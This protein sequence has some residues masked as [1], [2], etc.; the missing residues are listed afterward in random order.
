M[1]GSDRMMKLKDKIAIVT[2]SGRG[3][4]EAIAKKLASEGASIMVD[5][6]RIEDADRV[7][8]EI[9]NQGGKAVASKASVNHRSEV[10]D[11]VNATLKHF[12]AIH[13]LVN[14]AAVTRHKP[15]LEL[16]EEDWD[17]VLD[18]D[19]KGVFNCT[20]AVLKHLMEQRYGKIVN[21]SSLA[22]LGGGYE[23]PANYSAAKAGVVALTKVTARE[24]GPYN[25]NVNCV[26]PGII[27]TPLTYERRS[28][29]QVEELLEQRKRVAVL[30]RVGRP[31]DVANLVLFLVSEDSSYMSGQIIRI[32]GGRMDLL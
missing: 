15:I 28:K 16:T 21:I 19:L 25:I 7:A 22:G 5:D 9:K 32:D 20:Q 13:I 26:A 24:A 18:V 23:T 17:L 27:V 3:I 4:G 11:L 6:V 10:Q 14:N 1:K 30:G 12:N 31:E 29:E 8:Q 2:G